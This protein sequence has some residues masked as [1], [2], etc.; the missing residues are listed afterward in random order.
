MFLDSSSILVPKTTT[1]KYPLQERR[2]FNAHCVRDSIACGEP[3]HRTH[4][5]A[6]IPRRHVRLTPDEEKTT[7]P[8]TPP[9]RSHGPLRPPPRNDGAQSQ[10]ARAPTQTPEEKE[11]NRQERLAALSKL[12]HTRRK[13]GTT[14]STKRPGQ[15]KAAARREAPFL[16]AKARGGLL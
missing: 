2:T 7:P 1:Q 15:L 10:R 4:F 3:E 8:P 12:Q 9:P 5:R 14:N 6:I 11:W 16:R 13:R